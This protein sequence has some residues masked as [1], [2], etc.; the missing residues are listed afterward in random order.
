M[1]RKWYIIAGMT[2]DKL[3]AQ[4]AAL[5]AIAGAAIFGGFAAIFGI[6]AFTLAP[7]GVSLA[8][9][10]TVT[11]LGIAAC[12]TAGAFI[13][14]A[15]GALTNY[16]LDKGKKIC[17]SGPER[18]K[19]TRNEPV[20]KKAVNPELSGYTEKSSSPNYYQDKVAQSRTVTEAQQPQM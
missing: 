20:N 7:V 8:T 13:G 1:D 10:L 2:R 3:I 14:A 18:W 5:A 16:S 9:F 15:I 11:T 4:N 6:A 17:V 19:Q 12:A